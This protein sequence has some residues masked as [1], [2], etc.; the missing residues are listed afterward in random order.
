MS[1]VIGSSVVKRQNL[2]PDYALF[3]RVYLQLT[4]II[5]KN[6]FTH[7]YFVFILCGF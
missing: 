3:K 6:E 1:K 4:V 7:F 2:T 5:V